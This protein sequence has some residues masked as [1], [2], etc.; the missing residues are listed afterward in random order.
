PGC[1]ISTANSWLRN[2]GKKRIHAAVNPPQRIER[3]SSRAKTHTGN[4]RFAWNGDIAAYSTFIN[5]RTLET[6][7]SATN[8]FEIELVTFFHKLYTVGVAVK[9][10]LSE[11]RCDMGNCGRVYDDIL[12]LG[13]LFI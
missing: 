13:K 12:I 10:D 4:Q 7:D 8:I 9:M 6:R 11:L 1:E 2:S 3:A 5:P